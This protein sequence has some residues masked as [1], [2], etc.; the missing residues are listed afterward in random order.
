MPVVSPH[1]CPEP[2]AAAAVRS[3][4]VLGA[5]GSVGTSAVDLLKRGNGGYRVE[6]VTAHRNAS[7][8]AQIAVELRARFA[9]VADP[10]AYG[11]LK[12]ALAGTGIEAGS[13]EAALIEAAERPADWVMA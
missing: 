10:A 8:L 2:K 3:V 4:S 9:A 7:Q 5:T 13:G 11:E 6:A 1:A 12:D